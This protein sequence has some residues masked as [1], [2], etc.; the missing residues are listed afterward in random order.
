MCIIDTVGSGGRNAAADAKCVQLLLNLNGS[1]FAL[2]KPLA[3]DGLWGAGS[4]AALGAF[5]AAVGIAATQPVAPGDPTMAALQ[6]GLPAGL[7]PD[8]L[9]LV[10]IDAD[11]GR[12]DRFYQGVVDAMARR[13]IDTPL[14]MAHFLAQ[15]GHESGCLRYTE[16]L[17]S[18]EAY[19][20]RVDLGNTQPGDGPRFKGRG[21]IQLTGRANYRQYG[22]AC[23]QD[24]ESDPVRLRDD[25]A[26][27]VDVAAWYWDTRKL[28]TYADQD[29]VKEVTRRINGGYNGLPDRLAYLARAKWVLGA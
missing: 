2:A 27:A 29:D 9:R 17:A 20:G 16:E 3:V 15:V 13:C 8:K 21:L 28:N 24:F 5:R 10:M 18:G 4:Q 1:R 25:P 11:A 14:R 12:I 7:S 26:I 23:G 19:E 6:A 22:A